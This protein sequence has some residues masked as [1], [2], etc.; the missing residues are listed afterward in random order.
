MTDVLHQLIAAEMI[1]I[2]A[3]KAIFGYF[4]IKSAVDH[5]DVRVATRYPPRTSFRLLLGL[6]KIT[7][8]APLYIILGVLT[9]PSPN[10]VAL[11][12]AVWVNYCCVIQIATF[13]KWADAQGE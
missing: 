3:V 5:G 13:L 9:A 1:L 11:W 2:G 4:V 12:A 8:D 6:T 7:S 10:P